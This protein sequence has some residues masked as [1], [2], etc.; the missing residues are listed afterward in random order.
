MATGQWLVADRF[1]GVNRTHSVPR[2]HVGNTF[3]MINHLECIAGD[4]ALPEARFGRVKLAKPGGL[5]RKTGR[6]GTWSIDQCVAN[7]TVAIVGTR[8]RLEPELTLQA[9]W[10]GCEDDWDLLHHILRPDDGRSAFCASAIVPGGRDYLP[11]LP[12]QAQLAVLDGATAIRWLPEVRTPIV[13]VLIDRSSTDESAGTT[14]LQRRSIGRPVPMD[15]LRWQ[16]FPG[17]E[18]LAFEVRV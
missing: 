1:I 11:E 7:P 10:T 6:Q 18:A 15:S 13:V 9:G 5:V 16:P 14:V 12:S 8:S 3:W 2:V 4:P 17:M